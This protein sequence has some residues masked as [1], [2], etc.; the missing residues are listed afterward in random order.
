MDQD[1]IKELLEKYTSHLLNVIEE[2]G[3]ECL[4]YD[5][6]VSDV[7]DEFFVANEELTGHLEEVEESE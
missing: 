2:D 5:T 3:I 4:Y 7:I 6:T 1:D